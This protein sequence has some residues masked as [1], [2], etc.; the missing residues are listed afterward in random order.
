MILFS[1]A[2]QT[3]LYQICV[4]YKVAKLYLFGSALNEKFNTNTSDLDF[5]VELVPMEPLETGEILIEL[6]SALENLFKRKVDLLT[7]RSI[8]NPY[9][10][11]EIFQ[12]R[13]LLYDQQST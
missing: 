2:E 11:Q 1:R 4:Q 8:S 5:L 9:L 3:Q 12:T 7:E 10:L 6:W 13:Q